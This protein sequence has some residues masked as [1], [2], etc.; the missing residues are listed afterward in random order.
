[1]KL[2]ILLDVEPSM[3][4]EKYPVE[5]RDT[6]I[7]EDVKEAIE[8]IESGHDSVVEWKMINKLYKELR[9]MKKSTRVKNLIDMIEPVMS[10]YG[11]HGVSEEK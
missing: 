7:E 11:L 5:A 8:C 9:T 2:Q 4:K 6:S 3:P 10:K 1:M